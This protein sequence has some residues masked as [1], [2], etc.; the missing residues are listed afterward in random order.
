MIDS[1]VRVSLLGPFEVRRDG[2][3]VPVTGRAA[4]VLATLGLQAGRPVSTHTLADRVWGERLPNSVSASLASHITRLRRLLGAS[5]IRTVPAGYL[6]DLHPDRVDLLRLRRMVGEAVQIADRHRAR[7]LLGEALGSWRGEPLDGLASEALRREVAPSLVE[8]LLSAY[9]LRV[10]WDLT[11]GSNQ[12]LVA[13]LRTLTARYPLRETLWQQ[14]MAALA[15]SG[16]HGDAMAAYHELRRLL[17]Q[18]LGV[19]PSPRLREAYQRLLAQPRAVASPTRDGTEA[20][21][22][23][24]STAAGAPSRA[25]SARW[26]R[27][28]LPRD[29]EGFVGRE[30]ELRGILGV[31]APGDGSADPA[32]LWTIDGMAGVG[33]TVLAVHA[34]HLLAPHYPDGQLF[35]DLHGYTDGQPPTDPAVALEALL[36]VIGVVGAQVPDDL[37][38]RA[39]LWRSE[40]AGRRL[41]IVLDNAAAAATVR[42]LIPGTAGCLT[43]VTSRRRLT[44]LDGA[45]H[46]S[47][48]VLPAHDALALFSAVAGSQRVAGEPDAAAQVLRLCGNLPL[49]VHIAG[50][51][52]AARDAWTVDYLAQRL[53]DDARR[54]AE[55]AVGTRNAAG[56]FHVSYRHLPPGHQRMFRRLGLCPGADFDTF[57]AAAIAT[58]S[59]PEAERVLEDLVDVHLLQQPAPGRYRFHD[60]L[61]QYARAQA[62]REEDA[63]SRRTATGRALDYY[64]WMVHRARGH[65]PPGGL[66]RPVTVEYRPAHLP[67][68]EDRRHALEWCE[69]ERANLVAAVTYAAT[70]RWDRRVGQLADALWWFLRLRGCYSDWINVQRLALE[71]AERL[72]DGLARADAVRILGVATHS[73]GR[74]NQ[75]LD[76]YGRALR[77]YQQLGNRPGE[78]ITLSNIGLTLQVMGRSAEAVDHGQRALAVHRDGGVYE[79]AMHAN[80]A[81][82]YRS[83][84]R[85][86]EALRHNQCAYELYT[87]IGDQRGRGGALSN[88]GLAHASLGHADQA[89][90]SHRRAIELMRA[91]GDE[92]GECDVRNDFGETLRLLRRLDDAEREYRQALADAQRIAHPHFQAVAHQGIAEAV[93]ESDSATARYHWQQAVAIFTELNNPKAQRIQNRLDAVRP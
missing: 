73:S 91:A 4:V 16:R 75:A 52:L 53:S 12:G 14:L 71:A 57:V 80:I 8:E 83:L 48:D 43:I 46:L 60:L 31:L 17:R 74:R 69:T 50:A 29:I 26:P 59:P 34:A 36:R 27:R 10:E 33:K 3:L 15:G 38:E 85:L 7:Q 23:S 82:A 39:A 2:A 13:E 84:G 9:Q 1:G 19:D 70:E 92:V 56:A 25:G 11:D 63:A 30:A 45:R 88:L 68:M 49:A 89:V 72:D 65:F 76:C 87:L 93:H 18:R 21:G 54:W 90:A 66:P 78:A 86:H 61:R 51:R 32:P 28:E 22:T 35:T 47:L 41:I 44:E 42:P 77:M 62:D 5:T 40:L 67:A 24:A 64:L 58:V 6:L 55:L 20:F 37:D 79:A 81:V